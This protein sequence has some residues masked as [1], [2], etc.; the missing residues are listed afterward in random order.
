MFNGRMSVRGVLVLGTMALPLMLGCPQGGNHREFGEGDNVT[1]TDPHDHHHEHG[2]NGGHILELGEYHG[3]IAVT[4][5]RVLTLFVLGEDAKTPAPVA[6]ATAKALLKVGSETK[7]IP[8][9]SSPLEGETDGKS[10]RFAAAADALPAEIVDIEG[11][12]GEIILIVGG[13]EHKASASHDHGHDHDHD[14]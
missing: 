13:K 3:E 11:V 7:E 4:D 10:S 12:D 14:H 5:G 1:N 8:L 6:D 9:A 2:P